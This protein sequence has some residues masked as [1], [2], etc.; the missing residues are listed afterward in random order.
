MSLLVGVCGKKGSGKDVFAL[1]LCQVKGFSQLTFA[2]PLK[3]A[4]RAIFG[5]TEEDDKEKVDPF[6]GVSPRR[7]FQVLGTD[8]IRHQLGERLGLTEN[9]FVSRMRRRLGERGDEEKVV[10]SD[11]RFPD[12]LALLRELGGILVKIVRPGT[13]HDDH[14]SENSLEEVSPDFLLINDSSLEEFYRKIETLPF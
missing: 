13:L 8:L 1:R 7:V 11:V 6:W 12:E 9:I 14:E 4:T 10:V 3:E 5:F 2:G